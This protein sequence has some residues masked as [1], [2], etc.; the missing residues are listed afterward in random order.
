ML[1]FGKQQDILD[2]LFDDKQV[3]QCSQICL[4]M[5]LD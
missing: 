2:F 4:D 3:G 5:I 1:P